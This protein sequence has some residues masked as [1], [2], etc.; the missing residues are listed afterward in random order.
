MAK[1]RQTDVNINYKVNTVEIEKGNAL[2]NRA[3]VAT[4][5]LRK[6]TQTFGTQAGAAYKFTSKAIEGM[7][8]EVA[9]LR[10]QVKLASTQNVADVKRLSDQYKSAKQQ[11]DAYNKSLLEVSKNTKQTSLS[12]QQMARGFGDVF[13]AAKLFITAGVVKELVDMNLNMAK[14]SGNVQGVERAFNR[15]FPNSIKLLNDL[16]AATHGTVTEFELMQRTLQATN[17]GVAVEQLPILFEFAAARAQQTGESVDYLVDSIVRGIGRKS[18]LVLD[19]LGLSATRLREQFDGAS[20]ASQSVADV[21]RGVAE[22]ARVELGK[23]GGYAET[24]ATKVSQLTVKVEELKVAF[25]KKNEEKGN[26]I[27][28]F[29]SDIVDGVTN[30]VKGQKT[31]ADEEAKN[32][33]ARQVDALIQ[34]KEFKD[35]E[36]NQVAKMDFL[37]QEFIERRK[38][39]QLRE[40]EIRLSQQQLKAGI[41]DPLNVDPAGLQR[42]RDQI[43]AQQLSRDTISESIKIIQKY[44]AE[45]RKLGIDAPES[46]GLIEDVEEQIKSMGE[47]IK[48][49]KTT[50]EI[51]SLNNQLLVL[52]ATLQRLKDQGVNDTK[53]FSSIKSKGTSEALV[54]RNQLVN[55][56]ASI[57]E[58]INNIPSP[59]LAI[60]PDLT[61]RPDV[62]QRLADEFSENWRDI[63]SAGIDDTVSI[64]NATIQAEAESFN[65]R[66]KQAEEFYD[67]QIKLASDAELG[68]TALEI[69]RQ[70]RTLYLELQKER[71]IS[72]LRKQAFEAE[73]EA[74]RLQT[75]INGAAGLIKLWVQP[76]FPA[77]IPLAV[78][79]AGHTLAQLHTINQQQY[80][81]FAKGEIDIKG[82]TPGR[83]SIP[84][85]LMPRESVMTAN[86]TMNSG[87]IL[88]AIRA[89]KLN[90]KVLKEI[91]SG[92]SGGSTVQ[93][94]DINP[95]V[96]GLKDLKDSQ[97]DLV[98]R[99]NLIYEAR[100][101]GDQYI[102]WVRSKSMSQ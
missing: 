84:S 3:S 69:A 54:K 86:E 4:D 41:A 18:I 94:V 65:L 42:L 10:Q 78:M 58:A 101:S 8:I 52:E 14:L 49:A 27:A 82:G 57:Q 55:I 7:E 87:G 1:Q 44:I 77:A 15:A 73:K 62:W 5:N 36:K 93:P 81:G 2:L 63:I 76:G 99:G 83:D 43:S 9:R 92:R 67:R 45:L 70:R 37:F 56:G 21:T 20:L 64:I 60:S 31:L 25:A 61:F 74:Q 102:L 71:K 29:F 32:R 75:I 13:T 59:N 33:A 17:L 98:K 34:S 80:R 90:D 22:I 11:L 16:K 40:E 68:K 95:I 97:P 35:L 30:A 46:V 85:M 66:I 88:R 50:D 96:K 72:A 39:L 100:K 89:K 51:A 12:A 91:V 23:M 19:N 48:S 24:A 38:L 28:E 6:T 53:L 47:G 79:L 26:V